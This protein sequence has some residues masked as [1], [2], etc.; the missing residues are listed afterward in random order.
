MKKVK[1]P[2]QCKYPKSIYFK[3]EQYEVQF[4]T[5]LGCYGKTDG[6]RK[7]I[8]IKKAM[9]ERE[10]LSTFIHELLH[11][12]EFETPIKLKHKTIYKLEQSIMELLLDNFL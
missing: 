12:I 11:V 1:L 6:T 7:K 10:T 2:R 8:T 5:K 4:K 3:N 9:S